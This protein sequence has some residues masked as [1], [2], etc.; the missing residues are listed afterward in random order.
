MSVDFEEKPKAFLKDTMTG[1]IVVTILFQNQ[2]IH[3]Q[4]KC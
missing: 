1:N 2:K 4:K 3:I